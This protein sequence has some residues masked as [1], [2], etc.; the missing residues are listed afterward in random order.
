MFEELLYGVYTVIVFTS[1]Y[2]NVKHFET[3]KMEMTH[4]YKNV[5]NF[6]SDL[7]LFSLNVMILVTIIFNLIKERYFVPKHTT[8][9]TD[10][11][12]YLEITYTHHDEPYIFRVK[13]RKGPKKIITAESDKKDVTEMI[14]TYAGPNEDFHGVSYTPADLNLKDLYVFLSDGNEHTFEENEKIII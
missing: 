11:G 13:T 9:I 2:T 7:K 1:F 14:S 4:F 10:F 6:P 8:S 12:K 5:K 3:Y